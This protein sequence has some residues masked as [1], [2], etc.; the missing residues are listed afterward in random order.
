VSKTASVPFTLKKRRA[1]AAFCRAKNML[2]SA[3]MSC[4][5]EVEAVIWA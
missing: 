4:M 5:T 1:R 3:L 2:L